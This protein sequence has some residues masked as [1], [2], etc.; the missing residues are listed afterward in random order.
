MNN[1]YCGCGTNK[2]VKTRCTPTTIVE[3]ALS[4][5]QPAILVDANEVGILIGLTRSGSGV[6]F[7]YNRQETT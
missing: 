3:I 4:D 6:E 2:K 1:Y 7:E 5:D